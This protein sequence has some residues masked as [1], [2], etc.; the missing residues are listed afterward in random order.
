MTLLH[1][2]VFDVQ[3]EVDGLIELEKGQSRSVITDHDSNNLRT[4]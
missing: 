2:I 3:Q 1:F 4:S